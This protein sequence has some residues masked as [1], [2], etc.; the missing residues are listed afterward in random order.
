MDPQYRGFDS[1]EY[2]FWVIGPPPVMVILFS[3]KSKGV[4]VF[5]FLIVRFATTNTFPW[6]GE[7][8]LISDVLKTELA[9]TRT[10]PESMEA[11]TPGVPDI[12]FPPGVDWT[13]GLSEFTACWPTQPMRHDRRITKDRITDTSRISE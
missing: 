7:D 2:S 6:I 12:S 4:V 9:V 13:E 11:F 3:L 5:W 10:G 1:V 8:P